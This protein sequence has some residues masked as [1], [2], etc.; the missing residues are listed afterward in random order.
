MKVV[1]IIFIILGSILLINLL[2]E[3]LIL[4]IKNNIP[5]QNEDGTVTKHFHQIRREINCGICDW[6]YF[7]PTIKTIISSKFFEVE[8]D[9]FVFYIY[10]AYSIVDIDNDES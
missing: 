8:I 3:L 1:T 10:I 7:I 6:V 4:L 5:K 2:L 9:I